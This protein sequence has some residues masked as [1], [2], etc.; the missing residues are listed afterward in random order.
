MHITVI[1]RMSRMSENNDVRYVEQHEQ[2]SCI[3]ISHVS[4]YAKEIF[5]ILF[6]YEPI[7]FC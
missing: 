1:E 6:L 3:F 2:S 7:V 4:P 5:T